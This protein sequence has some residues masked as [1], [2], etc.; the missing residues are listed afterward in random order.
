MAG[1]LKNF[2][3][4]RL[5]RPIGRVLIRTGMVKKP[6]SGPDLQT[7][8]L[9]AVTLRGQGDARAGEALL[10][11]ALNGD[12]R[13]HAGLPRDYIRELLAAVEQRRSLA[14]PEDGT[15]DLLLEHTASL[16]GAL[17]PCKRWLV[18]HGACICNGLFKV[19]GAARD[20]AIEAA[21]VE[22]SAPTASADSL[23][24]AFKAAIDQGEFEGAAGFL[25]RL[26]S[27]DSRR[28]LI[29]DLQMYY[30]LNRGDI[31]EFRA[32]AKDRLTEGDSAFADYIK[33]ESM[34]IVGP[35][36]SGEDS[37]VEIDSFDIV[38]RFSYRGRQF[39]PNPEQFG[40]K[41]DVSYYAMVVASQIEALEDHAFFADLR[42]ALFKSLEHSFQKRLLQS[43]IGRVLSRNN[44]FF[45]G[46]P[47]GLQNALFDLLHFRPGRVKL[48]HV[49]FFLAQSYYHP[50]YIIGRAEQ[51]VS[52]DRPRKILDRWLG[53]AHHGLVNQLN[54]TRNL[55]KAGLIE[56]DNSCEAVLRLTPA[57]YM[58][59]IEE[60]Y[61]I[62]PIKEYAEQR[63]RP[64]G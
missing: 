51:A 20:K 32:L 53:L 38:A 63:P 3:P 5:R 27:V 34:A 19:A 64:P 15:P 41:V 11:R 50:G 55:W 24:Q 35:A 52:G 43:Q 16:D 40:T 17:L 26:R 36:P 21:Y 46:S 2:I 12:L 60:V 58:A 54:F 6:L 39:L 23:V 57:E 9:S 10:R 14:L 25:A 4:A 30:Y 22:A 33:G 29:D 59:A 28:S 13:G 45:D 42:F 62:N 61:V 1:T 47:M 49:N 44:S 8:I 37:G 56:A 48:F 18:L 7:K 31:Q